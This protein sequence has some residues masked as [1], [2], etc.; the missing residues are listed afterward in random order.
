M[1]VYPSR[2][3]PDLVRCSSGFGPMFYPFSSD[4]FRISSDVLPDWSDVFPLSSDVFCILFNICPDFQYHSLFHYTSCGS[5]EYLPDHHQNIPLLQIL[6]IHIISSPLSKSETH[7]VHIPHPHPVSDSYGI[8]A[9]DSGIAYHDVPNFYHHIRSIL[10]IIRPSS[11][12]HLK[13]I[14][15]LCDPHLSIASTMFR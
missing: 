13:S 1:G 9:L 2:L 12:T 10:I 11:D 4:V 5:S 14:P 8:F 7:P 15:H 6:S 3:H